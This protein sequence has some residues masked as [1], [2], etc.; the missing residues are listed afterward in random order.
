LI[1]P[2]GPPQDQNV[3]RL[4]DLLGWSRMTF[5]DHR[6]RRRRVHRPF[7]IAAAILAASCLGYGFW[8][9]RAD[10]RRFD[11]VAAGRLETAM[12]RHYY[13]GEYRGLFSALY[14]LNRAQYGFSPWDSFR[15]AY[16]AAR[17]S[18]AF[19]PSRSRSEAE[20]ALPF[21]HRYFGLLEQNTDE[22]FDATNAARLELEWWQLRR[23]NAA[24]VEWADVIARVEALIYGIEA[25]RVSESAL[26]RASMMR[27]RDEHQGASLTAADWTV[28]EEGLV[29][30]YR[31]LS[32]V[33][34]PATPPAGEPR[35][36][37]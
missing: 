20:R 16:Y 13:R 28:I 25:D 6:K 15:L 7:L 3:G 22:E 24:V 33:V 21:L 26:L 5:P 32:A 27:Y 10:L 29:R 18:A 30:S 1:Q 36:W 35:P 2:S 8:P 4:V 23:E 14:R 9:R 37:K 12:W 34:A 17:A 11:P 31:L 19:Q